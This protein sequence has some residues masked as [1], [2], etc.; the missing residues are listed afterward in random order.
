MS[1]LN[2]PSRQTMDY[3]VPIYDPHLVLASLLIASFASYVTL[4]LAERIHTTDLRVV[5][6]WRAAGSLSMDTGIW[7]MHF[8]GMLAFSLPISL[9]HTVWLTLASWIAAVGVSGLAL[10]LASHRR[11]TPTH[12]CGGALLMGEGICAMHYIGMAALE[13]TPDIVWRW[14]WWPRPRPS[15]STPRLWP[16]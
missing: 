15:P 16:C 11:L 1:L 2:L 14:A 12:L 9:G 3:L 6:G 10:W 4:N 7:S 13:M 5:R 8:V